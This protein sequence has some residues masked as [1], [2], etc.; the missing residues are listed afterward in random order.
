VVIV[1]DLVWSASES[2]AVTPR[3]G[4]AGV[5][6]FPNALPL[7]LGE[8]AQDAQHEPTGGAASVDAFP[9]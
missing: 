5:N 2:L 4:D 1:G 9:E 6:A 3:S 8:A 7:E